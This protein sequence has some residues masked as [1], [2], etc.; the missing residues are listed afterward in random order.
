[1]SDQCLFTPGRYCPRLTCVA[2][3]ACLVF[4]SLNS[5]SSAKGADVAKG[6]PGPGVAVCITPSA[7]ILRRPAGEKAWQI[8]NEKGTVNSG[9]LLVGMP[10]AKLE[11]QNGAVRLTQLADLDSQSRFPILESAVIL[12]RTAG[13][14]LDF[15]L[16]R[17]RVSVENIKKSGAALVRLHVYKETWD[18][19]LA[20]PGSALAIELYAR[21]ARGVPFK[22]EPDSKHAPSARLV[23]VVL[24]G[25]VSLKHLHH[26]LA[27]S[28]PPGPAMIEWDSV[29]GQDESAEHLD[30]LPV[31]AGPQDEDSAPVKMKL[32][33]LE[34][35]RQA[36]LK[37]PI[38]E[39][40]EEFVVAEQPGSRRLA[41]ILMGALDDIPDLGAAMRETKYTDVWENGVLALRH[42]IGRGPGQ[43]E[44]IYK[45]LIDSGRFKPVQ[46]ETVLQLLH[47]YGDDELARPEI[48]QTLI[49]YLSHDLLGIRGLAYWHLSRLVPAGRSL[50]YNP[51]G[52]K[53]EREAAIQKWR[54]LVPPGTVPQRRSAPVKK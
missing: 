11:T 37:K 2:V 45:A 26:H 14:D 49:D 13:V 47:S 23:M 40:I 28:A 48:Y 5:P 53:E 7:T 30:K 46:A 33:V 16:D 3:A 50:G 38:K 12:H 4:S 44:I 25:E 21:W 52:T 9:D 39:V 41:V 31:W 20:E 27:L 42:W 29:A 22:K 10:G 1:M 19:T 43:D 32:A 34:R 54:K 36:V 35:F 6:Q 18:L 8:V 24:K 51:L 17:G 15:T